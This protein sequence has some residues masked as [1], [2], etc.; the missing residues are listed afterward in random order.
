MVTHNPELAETYSTRIV[1]LL[2]GEIGTD[3]DPVL[4]HEDDRIA[5]NKKVKK[6]AMS[7]FTSLKLSANNLRTK[8]G[9]TFLTAFAGSIGIIGIATILALSTGV[10][11]Y[12]NDLQESTMQSYPVTIS[13]K[14]MDLAS[15]FQVTADAHKDTQKNKSKDALY[16]SKIDMYDPSS[17]SNIVENDLA[18][19]KKYIDKKDSKINKYVGKNGVVYSY[20]VSFGAWTY[21]PDDKLISTDFD[22]TEKGQS[23]S[24]KSALTQRSQMASMFTGASQGSE[25]FSE[26]MAGKNGKSVSDVVKDSYKLVAGKWPTKHDEVML[27]LGL[28]DSVTARNL[29]QLGFITKEKYDKLSSKR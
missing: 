10:N 26:V 24:S 12:I 22:P 14:T 21:G 2:D 9:R 13:S 28:D 17:S 20:K 25:N 29:Y 27:V 19:F 6:A 8:K 16:S 15:I 4:E 5:S 7:F 18:S 23:T 11:T 3:T 1:N